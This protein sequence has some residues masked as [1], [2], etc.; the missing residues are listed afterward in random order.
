MSWKF[1][2]TGIISSVIIVLGFIG[3]GM[4]IYLLRRPK[5]KSA[6]NQLLIALCIFDTTFL[7]SNIPVTERALGSSKYTF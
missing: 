2:L 6:F 4:A 3:N 1:W 5:M 7:L